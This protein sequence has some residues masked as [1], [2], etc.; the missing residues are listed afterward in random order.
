MVQTL[1]RYTNFKQSVSR[2]GFARTCIRSLYVRLRRVVHFECCRV[3]SD[4]G[5]YDWS[6]SPSGYDTRS[7]SQLEFNRMLCEDLKGVDYAWAFERGDI[8]IA[9]VRDGEIVGYSFSS[10]KPTFVQPGLVFKFPGGFIYA[11]AGK[12]AVLHRGK[13]LQ[14]ECWK[15][16]SR[17]YRRKYGTVFGAIWYVNVTNLESLASTRHADLNEKLHGYAGYMMCFG[18]W[19]TF[20]T[21]GCKRLGVGFFRDQEAKDEAMVG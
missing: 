21:P 10:F 3:A 18:R 20:A 7:V 5:Q 8:C 19:I 16:R 12:T 11:F 9:N 4:D 13:K 6:S 14:P 2:H 1:E 17:E 15:A